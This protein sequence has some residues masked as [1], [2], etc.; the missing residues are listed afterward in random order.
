MPR[1]QG[2]K[3]NSSGN[4]LEATIESTLVGKG[5]MPMKYREWEKNKK[6]YGAKLIL[7]NVPFY[8]IYEHSGYTEFLL[9]DDTDNHDIRIECKW[10]QVSGSVDEKFPYLYLNC[11]E[12]MKEKDIILVIDGD[13]YKDGAIKWLKDAVKSRV[14]QKY[15][16]EK[17]IRVFNLKEFIIWANTQF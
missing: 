17:N 9:K 10:Q 3:A 13:G 15:D 6:K 4:T 11:I 12:A 1:S 5:F 14:Y 8:T 7:K 16:C 2:N